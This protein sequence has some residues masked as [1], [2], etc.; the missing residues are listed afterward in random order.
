[1]TVDDLTLVS[2]LE[3][4]FPSEGDRGWLPEDARQFE[5][6]L[7]QLQQ[8]GV[9]LVIAD[10]D[11]AAVGFGMIAPRNDQLGIDRASLSRVL[12]HV[13]V[14]P[15]Y[16]K[17]G[18][19]SR[20][21][22]DLSSRAKRSGAALLFAHIPASLRAL[23]EDAGWTVTA[24]EAGIAWIE[25][26]SMQLWTD[27]SAKGMNA[28]PR[29]KLSLLR[30]DDADGDTEYPC[31]AYKVL[32]DRKINTLFAFPGGQVP[33]PLRAYRLLASLCIQR[34]ETFV[35]LPP[36]VSQQVEPFV[37]ELAGDQ[38]LMDLKRARR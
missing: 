17:R 3:R 38:A 1:M 20:L 28:G 12:T 36:D 34:P 29:R 4:L 5:D 19:G 7:P 26:P 37:R 27:M 18:V 2:K 23:Y 30:H 31:M 13:A 22:D 35:G 24:P 9:D 8:V 33:S 11:G 14:L 15:E 16:R 6:A 10:Y 32:N 25:E 21:L